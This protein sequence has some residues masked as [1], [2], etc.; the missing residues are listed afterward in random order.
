MAPALRLPLSA[1][2]RSIV[3]AQ[4]LDP[5]SDVF[6]VADRVE[7]TG[8]VST[9]LL[10]RAIEETVGEVDALAFRV[11][12]DPATGE[13][14]RVAVRAEA[15]VRVH[16]VS[17][18]TDPER[19][20]RALLDAELA[21]GAGGLDAAEP[22]GQLI[23]RTGPERVVWLQRYHH[24]AVD[25]YAISL[26]ARRV[27]ERY[28][29]LAG[30]GGLGEG[31]GSLEAL[32][33]AEAAAREACSGGGIAALLDAGPSP[34]DADG[35]VPTVS[36]QQSPA[37]RRAIGVDLALP[38]ESHK[39]VLRLTARDRRITWAD[40][41]TAAYAV[42][43][44]RASGSGAV[45]LGIPFAARTTREA[46]RTPSMSV[47]VLPLPVRVDP[48]QSLA[49]LAR[50]V[51]EGLAVLRR[52]QALRGEE[53]AAAR[54]IPSL[55]RGPGVNLKPYTPVLDFG[56]AR[57]ELRTEAAGPVDDLDLS[58]TADERGVALRVDAN[59]D[60]YTVAELERVAARYAGLLER[61]LADPDRPV[62]RVP[63]LPR[64]EAGADGSEPAPQGGL[65]IVDVSQ[66][67]ARAAAAD[68]Q[69]IAVRSGADAVTFGGLHARVRALAERLVTLGAGPE[70]VVAVALPRGADLVVALLAVLEAGAALTPVDLGYP[71]ERIAF[72][73]ED[74][75]PV[76]VLTVAGSA[77]ARHPRALI[78]DDAGD[79]PGAVAAPDAPDAAHD[80]ASL[81][82]VVY[83]S[84][85][86]G[87]PKGVGVSRGALAYF[88]AHHAAALFGPT[89]ARA[90]RRLRAAHTAS[91]SFDSSWEQLLWLLL[92]HELVVFDEDDR[93]DARAIVEAID[94]FGIDTLDVTPSF[95]SA[96]VHAG[97]LETAHTPEL[98]LIGGEAAPADLWR[99]LSASRMACHNFYGPTEATVD[100][101]GAPVVGEHPRI[102]RALAGADALV[103]DV[104]LQPVPVGVVGEL[105]LGGPHLARGYQGRSALTAARF[106]A[107]PRGGGRRLYRTGDLVRVEA[108]GALSS[109][110]RGDD[111]VK[112]R[113]HRVELGEVRD[114][115]TRLDGVG[116]AAACVRGAG[117]STRLVA[118]V[119][120][121]PGAG[122]DPARLLARLRETTPDHLVPHAV[123]VVDRLPLTAHGKLDVAALPEPGPVGAGGSAPVTDAERLVCAAV[124]EVL[125]L[126]DVP[127]DVDIVTL[128][129]D[130]ITAIA[131]VSALRRAGWVARPRDLFA[132]RTARGLAALLRPLAETRPRA[133]HTAWGSVPPTPVVRALERLA[134]GLDAVRA[135]AQSV[136][137]HAPGT[138]AP[139]LRAAA[140]ALAKRHPVLGLVARPG[141]AGTAPGWALE[142]PA[143]TARQPIHVVAVDGPANGDDADTSS[144]VEALRS[145]LVGSLDPS[146]G[147]VV[148]VGLLAHDEAVVVAA[149]HLVV[150]GVSWRVII[151]ELGV[152][153]GGGS[154]PAGEDAAWLERALALDALQPTP[155]E[156]AHW[157]ALADR[158]CSVLPDPVPAYAAGSALRVVRAAG[159]DV[160]EA[161]LTRLPSLLDARPDTVLAGALAA[162]LREWRGVAAGGRLLVDWETHGRDPLHDGEDPSEGIGWF[163]TEFPVSIEF[164]AGA[165]RADDPD[166]LAEAVRAARQARAEA[167]GDGY[168]AGV[169]AGQARPAVL[170][171][172]LGRFDGE[173]PAGAGVAL[174]GERPFDVH[175]PDGLGIGHALEVAVFVLPGDAGLEVEW[176]IAPGLA[177]VAEALLAAWDRA[178]AGLVVLAGRP[179]A[180]APATLI[181]A[182]AALPGL[183]AAQI[184]AIEREH[185]PLRDIAPLSPMQEGLLFHALRDGEDDVYTTV[186]TVHLE[187]T[188][189]GDG[190]VDPIDA[191][192][193]AA[194]VEAVVRAHPQ[195][196]AAFVVDAAHRPVQLVPRR[197]AAEVTVHEH[198]ADAQR[199]VAAEL[200]RH[201]DVGRPPLLRAHVAPAGPTS[202]TL[203][204][205]AHHLLLDGWSTP[206][207]IDRV[208][209]VAAGGRPAEGWPALRRAVLAQVGPQLEP[210]AKEGGG[211]SR[212]AWRAHLDGLA[213]ASIV[214]PGASGRVRTRSVAV[215]L[216]ADAASRLLRT[217]RAAGLTV[218]TVLTGAWAYVVAGALGRADVVVGVTTAG[219]GAAVEGV[220]GVVG[221]LSATVPARFR[222]RPGRPL[223]AQLRALQ[224]ERADLQEH[225]SLPL[226]D[227]EAVAGVGTLFDT[228]VVVENYPPGKPGTPGGLQV[229]GMAAAGSTHYAIGITA[230]PGEGL[231]VE[232]DHDE[233][234]VPAERAQ[235]LATGLADVLEL[236]ADGLDL[237]PLALPAPD[238]AVVLVGPEP[239]RTPQDGSGTC[240][241]LRSLLRAAA[242]QPDAV[243]VRFRERAVTTAELTAMAG[244]IQAALERAG[245]RPEHVVALALP[246]GVEIV[247]AI[248]ACLSAGAAYLPLDPALPPA[249]L[250]VLLD[251]AGVG[252]VVAARGSEA[253]RLAA[254]A[255]LTVVDPADAQPARL[256]PRAV[257]GAAAA[258]VIH[259]SG[260]TGRPKGVVLTRDAL[261]THFDG[262]RT[263][264][265]AELVERLRAREGRSRV[266]AVHSASFSFDTSL[267]QLHWA[268]AG[269]E[270][271][272][273][274]ED[275]RRDPA[276]FTARARTAD[277]IDVA[278]VLAEQLVAA[279]IADGVRPLPEI[280]LGGEAVAPELWTALRERADRTR[281]LNLYGPT[282]A[283]V[284][285]LGAVVADSE[286]PLIGA[287]VAG[288]TATILDP[289]LRPAPRGVAGELYLSGGQLARGYL[290]RPGLTAASFVAGPDGTRRYRTGDLVRAGADDQ[291]EHLGRLDD[292][293]K[294]AGHRIEPGEVEAALREVPGVAQAAAFADVPGPVASRLLAAVTGAGITADGV[295]GAVAQVLPGHLTPSR[296]LVLDA[297]PVTTSGKVDRA[298]LRALAAQLGA[299]DEREVIAPRTPQEAAVVGAVRAALGGGPV[300]VDDDFFEL[301]GHSLTAL[302]VIGALRAAGLTLGVRDVFEARVIGRIA[303]RAAPVGVPA[304]ALA[305]GVVEPGLAAG[306]PAGRVPVSS[307]QRGLLFLAELEG[308]SATYTVPVSFDVDGAVDAEALAAAWEGV[309]RRHPVLRT[310][311][312][313]DDGGFGAETLAEP[314][315]SFAVV[316]L[317][318]GAAT[319]DVDHAV[320]AE[321]ARAFDVFD[322]PPV[323][324]TLVASGRRAAL[325]IAAHHVAVDEASF[326]VILE[327]L[328]ALLHGQEP[329]PA[330]PFAVFAAEE[331]RG[332]AAAAA[333]WRGRLAGIPAEAE[334]PTDR[335]RPE[336]ASHR[337]HTVS[338]PVPAPLAERLAAVAAAE[339]ATPLMVVQTAVA[340]LWQALGAGDDIVLGSPVSTRL[341][342]RF[343]RTVGYLVNTLP[344]RLDVSGGEHLAGLLGRT[345]RS[346]L[347]AWED[348]QTPF[349]EVV[350]AVAPPRSLSRHPLFQTMAT[351][352]QPV[353]ERL[354]L[355]GARAV[356]RTAGAD[357]ARFDLAVRLRMGDAGEP[358]SLTLVAA[359]D[360]YDPASARRLLERLMGWTAALLADPRRP[361]R[362]IDGRLEDER[363]RP[364]V[365][366]QVVAGDA[367]LLGSLADAVAA[368][369]DRLAVAAGDE[370][371]DY[372]TLATRVLALRDALRRAGIGP[373]DRVAVATGRGSEL[374]VALLG[375]LAAGAAYVPLDVDYP[376]ARLQMMLDDADPALVLVDAGTRGAG[377]GRPELV[378]GEAE[379]SPTTPASP[380][381]AAGE[382]R[383]AAAAA[384][385][386]A[387]AYVIYTS[388]STGRPKGVAVPRAALDAFL[389]HERAVLGLGADDRLLAVTT[390]SFDIAALEVFVPL[391][392]G[393]AIVLADGGQVR[394]PDQLTALAARERCTLLQATPS[395]WRPLVEAH[396]EA[397][398]GV[399]ALVGGEALP[400]DLA[401]AMRQRC[402]SVRN[403]YGPTEATVWATSAQVDAAPAMPSGTAT[404]SGTAM[405]IGV[406]FAGV[407]AQVLDPALR[408]VPDSVAGELYLSG[409]QVARG[410][411]GRAGLTAS[412]FVADPFGE[413]GG[414]LYRTGDVVRRDGGGVLH[415]LRRADDQ[416]K[417]DG[418]RIELGEVEAAL[419]ELPGVRQAAAVVRPGPTG[420]DRLLGYVVVD[421]GVRIDG[422]EA[423]D[424]LAAGLPAAYVPRVVT[425]LDAI[426]LTLNGKVARGSLPEPAT[427]ERVL[428]APGTAAERA[429]VE[430]VAETLGLAA[431]SPDDGFFEL[432]GDS[433]SSIRL[434]A[435]VRARGFALTPG[436]VFSHERLA[437][438][439]AAATPLAPAPQ[440]PARRTRARISARDLGSIER[441]LEDPR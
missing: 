199:L 284:D 101:L 319:A 315:T 318:P 402:R 224:R 75:A 19:A 26:I 424:A 288:V 426:P 173:A 305:G 333:R 245:A 441:L 345:C 280:L 362:A 14:S 377:R 243:S 158:G 163:T 435:L 11:E 4:A 317:G 300:S 184:R 370:R 348:A 415:F 393:A 346:V 235:R 285:A 80:A 27:A 246:R 265:H 271:V 111:Q 360:L 382:L 62:G 137:L 115:V 211:A 358:G 51:A 292:Q 414:R 406:P 277:V 133:R 136:V 210:Q 48:A 72:L 166:F 114:A 355:P 201:T 329:A 325:V 148:A 39:A 55:L 218:S 392:S 386:A 242:A 147:R 430:A 135:Y 385:G 251:D 436:L 347:D 359:A 255:G 225:E 60:T 259:T 28:R 294:I 244:G 31:F 254:E 177:D 232:L 207:L 160:A 185:G 47:T 9:A 58:V 205:A 228:L 96:L 323:R 306:A 312:V 77:A 112:I 125:G 140:E 16:D 23:V 100:A 409:T 204:L 233:A 258:Y 171:N 78:L 417:V 45:V 379:A 181:P 217:A 422:Q 50:R 425:I 266:I 36:G 179:D 155:A 121:A 275:E 384:P 117:G 92:G 327:D 164:P 367:T 8:H 198:G 220:D 304:P 403:V 113:G 438:L 289:W 206:I 152:L 17:G 337:A 396:P 98:F 130:S 307:A 309:V 138:D 302:R 209:D 134:P 313:R 145:L 212:E 418:H 187:S 440:R 63:A 143:P 1:A 272:V 42:F 356:E 395:L 61:L 7:L 90:G 216:D 154:L 257:P 366:S 371:L 308:V 82:Y 178:L 89:A 176:T 69:A 248:V 234:R 203:V 400:A 296:V 65:D 124:G 116:H 120:P 236:L 311:Y 394:D 102:G 334:L 84:G 339:G 195:L 412:R 21:R 295:R 34:L 286:A 328:S 151:R 221:L 93:R 15:V 274:D 270:L 104:A 416:V 374:V 411:L 357:S 38:E 376:Q 369:P 53:I 249:R 188:P 332:D 316:D 247:A 432:G 361:V 131:I 231:R 186:T 404:P 267:I 301:G 25:G 70:R 413:P 375:V 237:T 219:R 419:R 352:E 97:L 262:L 189:H 44:A 182:E 91:F 10:T 196:G 388:G 153:L 342:E 156:E 214:A 314:P 229:A 40:V 429:V 282:E 351:V 29:A 202:A 13:P 241:A 399:A 273:L 343:A 287:P 420:R 67:L 439:A 95:A 94:A 256:A 310:V 390:V 88:L 122:L 433:I 66:A 35:A 391:M 162:A 106:I 172:Y 428:R 378:L 170:L 126:V 230:L 341:D 227:I 24:V 340:T 197:A 397:W 279:G 22:I 52:S 110:G 238:G 213:Q 37:V 293:V 335:P 434:V 363:R 354:R 81:A 222:M 68:P 64:G 291:V 320:A 344:V 208:L 322:A 226:A 18:E 278:P 32:V 86:T 290:G 5:D 108:D 41:H 107:D 157:R 427:A 87:R 398:S 276:L 49:G 223:G 250:R 193:L 437:S 260:S 321:E 161:V 30:G 264:R 79:L 365:D 383:R 144:R 252:L 401:Q 283:T 407:G 141:P 253:A 191:H 298:A 408:P 123:V 421:P 118:Y 263:G 353:G 159:P 168:G 381:H 269:H 410:Y 132:A 192:G 83:T 85:S 180:D 73:L 364:A 387:T 405:P 175:L 380:S 127:V 54:G 373:E 331:E 350:D 103:L 200:A 326:A 71:A 129:G 330:V 146:A 167:P 105:Y 190:R 150:D 338:A 239:E 3:D 6:V 139:T 149:H 59:P 299:E 74:S 33:E 336:R 57:G 215:P 2:Q 324:C 194:A 174:L 142:I 423:R 261:D 268:F 46:A 165:P 128:G 297:L 372:G 349:E 43:V 183:D 169:S 303:G 109:H 431:V 76:V 56:G 389:A 240:A 12:R 20:A 368:W 281:S 119:V 99:R